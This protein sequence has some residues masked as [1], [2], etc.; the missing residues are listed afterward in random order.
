MSL[1]AMAVYDTLDNKRTQFTDRTLESLGRTVDFTK[2]RLFICDNNSCPDTWA[3][4]K[5]YRDQF[6]F[7]VISNSSNVGTAR[8]INRAWILRGPGE[9]C[10][11]MDNDVVIH[12]AGWLDKLGECVE[13]DPKIGIIG[14][15]RKDVLE[16][17]AKGR[18]ELFWAY[19]KALPH[20]RGQTWLN[21]EVVNHVI[22]TCQLYNSALL[23]K[24][25][26]LYQLGGIY[27]FDDSLA[28]TRCEIAGFYSC[29]YPHIDIDHI[30]C[31]G[32]DYTDW[33]RKYSGE[34]INRFHK[35]REEFMLG[36]RSVWCGPDQDD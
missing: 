25:G 7:Q 28:A 26:Y 23:D 14:L 3:L 2:H 30:D 31:G 22:G 6:E 8:A 21:V 10:V 27:G 18:D 1:L 19:S 35:V 24:I 13:R 32:D 11:K 12:Q 33:K 36:K 4:Y 17:P 16:D 29:F 20:E 15:K 34:L 5:K 9:H